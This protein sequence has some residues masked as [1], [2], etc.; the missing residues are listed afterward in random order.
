M[1]DDANASNSTLGSRS[2]PGTTTEAS[3]TVPTASSG[4]DDDVFV[5]SR[6][7]FADELE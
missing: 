7:N 3:V 5:D 6:D 4:S 1:P 2:Q